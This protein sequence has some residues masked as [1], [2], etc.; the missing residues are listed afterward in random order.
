VAGSLIHNTAP[1]EIASDVAQTNTSR[2]GLR[3]PTKPGRASLCEGALAKHNCRLHL[4][5]WRASRRLSR[6]STQG[7]ESRARPADRPR[8]L[9]ELLEGIRDFH[10]V[11]AIVRASI[12]ARFRAAD[13]VLL[14][15]A[16]TRARRR[17]T[18]E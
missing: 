4:V 16:Q 2:L 7:A 12:A 10:E 14:R 17:A 1:G 3:T 8:D 11:A 9:A 15:Q 6:R 18:A 13:A 5:G